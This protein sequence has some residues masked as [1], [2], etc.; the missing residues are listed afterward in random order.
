MKNKSKQKLWLKSKG[1]NPKHYTIAKKP[2]AIEEKPD[3]IIENHSV[4]LNLNRINNHLSSLIKSA[5]SEELYRIYGHLLNIEDLDNKETIESN[6]TKK[7]YRE[8]KD[9]NPEDWSY[10]PY[11]FLRSKTNY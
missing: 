5:T 7:S 10:R 1:V 2:N 6:W 3:A 8:F 4:D 9:M 11:G